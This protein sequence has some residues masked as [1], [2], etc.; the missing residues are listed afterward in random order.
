MV[1]PGPPSDIGRLPS[2]VKAGLARRPGFD[3]DDKRLNIAEVRGQLAHTLA[4]MITYSKAY[5][6]M[7]EA[8]GFTNVKGTSHW[9]AFPRRN[10]SWGALSEGTRRSLEWR[11][12]RRAAAAQSLYRDV[13]NWHYCV[14]AHL[15]HLAYLACHPM[16]HQGPQLK[17]VVKRGTPEK[18]GDVVEAFFGRRS[19]L[20]SRRTGAKP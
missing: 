5:E 16:E 3:A 1:R 14:L 6:M 7:C 2:Q 10:G 12:E 15:T 20:A 18:C 11:S 4:C 8:E 17:C 19:V 13:G 9:G